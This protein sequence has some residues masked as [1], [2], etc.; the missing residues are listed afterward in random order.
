MGLSFGSGNMGARHLAAYP[1]NGRTFQPQHQ[2]HF[3]FEAMIDSIGLDKEVVKAAVDNWSGI[4]MSNDEV[5]LYFLNER[6]YV[7]GQA[8]FEAGTLTIKDFVDTE[9]HRQLWGWRNK[10]YDPT[11]GQVGWAGHYK[12]DAE[13]RMFAP[14]G[15]IGAP[16]SYT[17]KGCWPQSFNTGAFDYNGSDPVRME[18]TIRYDR[19][20][21]K[22]LAAMAPGPGNTANVGPTLGREGVPASTNFATA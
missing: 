1:F 8:M 6:V 2:N 9:T 10:V 12:V 22:N 14:D 5:E 21:P 15:G 16:R 18:C 3:V 20:Y 13:L 17:L 11:N 4:S 7:A 19:A